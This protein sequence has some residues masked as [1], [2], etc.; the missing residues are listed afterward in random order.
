MGLNQERET[1]LENKKYCRTKEQGWEHAKE[2][3]PLRKVRHDLSDFN[4]EMDSMEKDMR[5]ANSH[6]HF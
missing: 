6:D 2:I 1:A 5:F 4:Q 3:I